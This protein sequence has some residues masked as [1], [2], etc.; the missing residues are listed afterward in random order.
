ML[1][2]KCHIDKSETDF[3]FKIK[4]KGIRHRHCRAC[5]NAFSKEHYAKN[6]LAVIAKSVAR[7]RHARHN[8]KEYIRSLG[9]FCIKCKADHPAVLDFHHRD[10]TQKEM[11]ISKL[12]NTRFSRSRLMSEIEKC[13]VLCSNCHRIHHWN[14]RNEIVPV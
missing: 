10:P 14:E 6:K 12:I 5:A 11:T 8:N 13:D 2:T 9:L 3:A 1:C 4:A 7:S